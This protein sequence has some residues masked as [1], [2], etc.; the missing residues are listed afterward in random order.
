LKFEI[1][2]QQGDIKKMTDDLENG[3]ESLGWEKAIS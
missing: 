1:E 2:K 3:L